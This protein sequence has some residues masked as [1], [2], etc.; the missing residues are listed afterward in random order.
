MRARIEKLLQ[1]QHGYVPAIPMP[2]TNSDGVTLVESQ[3]AA[4]P[5]AHWPRPR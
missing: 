2:N 3:I 1:R 4:G 5:Y